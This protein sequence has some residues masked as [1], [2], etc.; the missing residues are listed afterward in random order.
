MGRLAG[1]SWRRRARFRFGA[2]QADVLR[3]F[4]RFTRCPCDGPT[5][6]AAARRTVNSHAPSVPRSTGSC[7]LPEDGRAGAAPVVRTC[8]TAA[9]SSL[10]AASAS[11][12]HVSGLICAAWQ[13]RGVHVT[14]EFHRA[15]AREVRKRIAEVNRSIQPGSG[16]DAKPKLELDDV[17]LRTVARLA[18]YRLRANRVRGKRGRLRRRRRMAPHQV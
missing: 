2:N 5:L 7:G 6:R 18:G 4:R 8:H 17:G 14:P 13:Q 15:Q 12:I 11:T 3:S 10:P 16:D 9:F 1:G